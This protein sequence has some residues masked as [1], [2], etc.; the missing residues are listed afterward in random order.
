MKTIR[1][2]TT[3]FEYDGPQLFEARAE[4]KPGPPAD[5]AEVRD[6]LIEA[7]KFDLVGPWAGHAFAEEGLPGWI[8][9]SNWYLTG[10][11]IPSD[12]SAQQRD[13]SDDSD[14][15]VSEEAGLPEESSEERRAAKKG[16][17]PSSMG[18]SFLASKEADTLYVTVRWGDYALAATEDSDGS[19]VWQRTPCTAEV[20]VS[21]AEDAPLSERAVPNS[22][23]LRLHVVKHQVSTG[24]IPLGTQAVSV[25]LVN[26]RTPADDRDSRYAFQA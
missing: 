3:L 23:G 20:E 18:L 25:F 13:D 26:R 4:R 9:P 16:Y 17:F 21:L 12:T 11:L 14:G 10:F 1:H 8:R 19:S 5:S 6:R 2:T 22:A 24:R 7:L 15:E